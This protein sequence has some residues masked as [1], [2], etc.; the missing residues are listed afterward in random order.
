MA[1]YTFKELLI[2]NKTETQFELLREGDPV[3]PDFSLKSYWVDK[4]KVIT[5]KSKRFGLHDVTMEED[6]AREVGLL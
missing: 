2:R 3:N 6:Y 1:K 4:T 5:Q